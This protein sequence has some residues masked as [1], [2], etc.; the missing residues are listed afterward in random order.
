MTIWCSGDIF[1]SNDVAVILL[2]SLAILVA[3]DEVSEVLTYNKSI[4]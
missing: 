4:G 1:L 3:S 2:I